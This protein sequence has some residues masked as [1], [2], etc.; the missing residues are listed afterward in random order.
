MPR[1]GGWRTVAL[2]VVA[3]LSGSLA[4][5]DDAPETR[6]ASPRH[7]LTGNT[8]PGEDV[9]GGPLTEGEQL[10]R[11]TQLTEAEVNAVDPTFRHWVELIR[12]GRAD[13]RIMRLYWYYRSRLAPFDRPVPEGW[14]AR[15]I[16]VLRDA[17]R[18]RAASA[19]FELG[20]RE[21]LATVESDVLGRL[22][23]DAPAAGRTEI[24]GGIAARGVWVPI[25]PYDIA[26]RTTGLDRPAGEP[27]TLYAAVADGGVWRTRDAGQTWERLSDFEQT[28]S[29]GAILL[30]PT[31]PATIY[32][33]TGEGNLA[34]DNY[35]GIGVL[36]S[37][38]A[39]LTWSASNHFSSSVRRLAMH[40]SEPSR[41]WAAGDDG[42]Y[43]STDAG[44]TFSVVS[45][46]GLPTGTGASDV[47][48]RPDDPD[49]VY[50]ALWGGDVG[51]IYRS[52]DRGLS[53]T[54]LENGL[55]VAGSVGR[56][57]L[58]VHAANPDVM[59]AGVD[60]SGGTI[61]KTVDAGDSWT[62]PNGGSL[63]Y[64][65]GQCWYDNVVG[66][67]P[68]NPDLM[69]AGGVS[70]Y[71]SLDGG[72]NWAVMSSGVHVDHHHILTPTAGEVLL[73]NDGGIYH[74]SNSGDSWV[75]WSLGMDTSQYYGICRHASND[76]WAF[77][78][79]QDN[80]S[81][82]RRQSDEW[83]QPLG[84]DGGMCMAGPDASDVIVGEFQNHNMQR[85]ADDGASWFSANGGMGGG[86]PRSWIGILE[87]DPGNRNNMWTGRSRIYR[88]LDARATDWESVS[89]PLYFGL[90]VGAIA[91]APSDSATVYA[92]FT[93]GGL[94]K[95]NDAL[96]PSPSWTDIRDGAMPMTTVRRIAVHPDD[97][98]TVYVVISGFGAQRIWKSDDGGATWQIRT[99][100]LPDVPVNDMVVDGD[101]PG[102]LIVATDLAVFRSDD[103]GA[104]WYG[105]SSGLP[106]A[107]AIEF[108]YN[109]DTGHLRVGTHGR[110]M[111]DWK[112]AVT[113]PV[114]VPDGLHAPGAPLRATRLDA[115]TMRVQWD[116][117]GTCVA[118]TYNLLYGDLDD[119]A[120]RSYSGAECDIGNSGR[121]DLPIPATASGNV[122]FVVTATDGAGTEGAH[123]YDDLG[124]PLAANGIGFC[125][126]TGQDALATCP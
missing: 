17:G 116:V 122:F 59:L 68:V 105:F 56:I 95:T 26:G 90:S 64:C 30:D 37:T 65:G 16:A 119:V 12:T 109:R 86:E 31:D 124:N 77:G 23:G 123:G 45:A 94:Y 93:A 98:D 120:T 34:I 8:Q 125:G 36:K 49:R 103:D 69:Y 115:T 40:A 18:S 75:E 9:E 88:S 14:R 35:P 13:K 72:A 73:A 48:V 67:D 114:P 107:A 85:S 80:G 43:V 32:F 24:A 46:P 3:T 60:E 20:R 2:V 51:G 126:V 113:T 15:G 44:A 50:C 71:R 28:L 62:V 81:H 104:T 118:Q 66:I 11:W 42:C 21:R 57:S 121:A 63:G 78:G 41:I 5:Q 89:G 110:S 47:L 27:D 82:R 108:T 29:G 100:D 7:G 22:R 87:V 70:A 79:T 6:I 61:Y 97:R 96:D 19:A 74:S 58:A 33:G 117:T 54:L 25:G 4:A 83:T 76:Y 39:G 52:T 55:P 38:D 102:T 53:W 99:G 101:N 1:T 106:T 84:G 92:G 112:P 10:R 111:W 91:I